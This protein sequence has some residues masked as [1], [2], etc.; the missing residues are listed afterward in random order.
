MSEQP[1]NMISAYLD[2]ELGAEQRAAFENQLRQD[3]ALR[4]LVNDLQLQSRELRDLP[5]FSLGEHFADRILGDERL[6]AAF[7]RFADAKIQLSSGKQDKK[8]RTQY[9]YW[10]GA[11]ASLAALV[12]IGV[13]LNL[14]LMSPAEFAAETSEKYRT[15]NEEMLDEAML[16]EEVGQSVD[17]GILP[18]TAVA[19]S[20]AT[21]GAGS[22]AAFKNEVKDQ[23]RSNSGGTRKAFGGGAM[24]SDV[25]A[26]SDT[27]RKPVPET[28]AQSDRLEPGT[29]A[30]RPERI[31]KGNVRSENSRVLNLGIED[32]QSRLQANNVI[33]LNFQTEG[34]IEL[35]S[36]SLR[37]NEILL[38]ESK[39]AK[40]SELRQKSQRQDFNK[41]LSTDAPR[42]FVINATE[43]QVTQLV[44]ELNRQAGI[45]FRNAVLDSIP[46]AAESQ[47]VEGAS[48]AVA[49]TSRKTR[50]DTE[51]LADADSSNSSSQA[52]EIEFAKALQMLTL[53]QPSRIRET[54]SDS[55]PTEGHGM[56]MRENRSRSQPAKQSQRART[57]VFFLKH[58]IVALDS[59]ASE[60]K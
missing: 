49:P 57:F 20:S 52:R 10:M 1:E 51:I 46:E 21:E 36:E 37:R 39:L 18:P 22:E 17:K 2:G 28:D 59:E 3:A 14:P 40:Q 12:L 33:E 9:M 8:T 16:D 58:K 4:D 48:D 34:G 54:E 19:R 30:A 47:V 11:A 24:K 27:G 43:A 23:L 31:P 5:K 41:S 45:S 15:T 25:A 38:L 6:E 29:P 55:A 35:F 26:L 32:F 56:E 7:G 50:D 42:A 53:E 44:A 60:D 13:F